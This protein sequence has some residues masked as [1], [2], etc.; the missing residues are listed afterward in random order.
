MRE[1]QPKN[2]ILIGFVLVLI[3]FLV[4]L[5]M[6]LKLIPSTWFLNFGSFAASV[7]GLFL[8]L[9]GTALYSRKRRD[10]GKR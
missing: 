8:G 6:T 1:V 7:C 3:G 9:I 10:K 4:P 2:I 5:A